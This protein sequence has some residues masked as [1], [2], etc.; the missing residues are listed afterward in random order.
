MDCNNAGVGF[1]AKE[2]LFLTGDALVDARNDFVEIVLM[3]LRGTEEE[4]TGIVQL[5]RPLMVNFLLGGGEDPSRSKDDGEGQQNHL[6]DQ[7]IQLK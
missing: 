6:R 5:Q 1:R 2:Q 3:L 4:M 7:H